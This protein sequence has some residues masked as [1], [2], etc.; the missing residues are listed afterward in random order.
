MWRHTA[1]ENSAHTE[2]SFTLQI[3]DSTL[4]EQALSMH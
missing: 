2:A 3:F 1:A 4:C